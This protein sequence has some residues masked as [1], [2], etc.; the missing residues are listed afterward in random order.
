MTKIKTLDDLKK[1]R[2]SLQNELAV[3][4]KSENP[5]SLVQIRVGMG[6]CGIAS[7]AKDVINFF[8]DALRKRDI[9]AVV[10]QTGCMGYCHSEPTVEVKLQGKDSILFGKVDIERAD[11][12]I[13]NYIKNGRLI[14]GVLPI[15]FNTID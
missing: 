1:M 12:I 6:T 9:P 10:T 15:I 7:G 14:D 5:E 3:R 4:E 13:E 2:N 8:N 11:E